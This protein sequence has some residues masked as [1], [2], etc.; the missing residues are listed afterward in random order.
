MKKLLTIALLISALPALAQD[1]GA[2]TAETKK[3]VMPVVPK[4]VA[5]MQ[6]AF[7]AKGSPII[8]KIKRVK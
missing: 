6:E 7:E 5:A 1:L 8:R 2:L 3:A 4:V